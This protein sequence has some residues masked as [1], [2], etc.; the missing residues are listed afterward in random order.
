MLPTL[1]GFKYAPRAE[2][3]R[4]TKALRARTH[5]LRANWRAKEKLGAQKDKLNKTHAV[6]IV[7]AP[8]FKSANK[9]YPTQKLMFESYFNS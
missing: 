1:G 5:G 3:K 8:Q 9:A 2:T 6:G 7:P 4:R